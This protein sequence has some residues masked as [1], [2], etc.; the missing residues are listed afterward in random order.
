L[1]NA[2]YKVVL[3]PVTNFYF[4]MAHN[5]DV[6]EPGH[7]WANFTELR[8]VFAFNP[9]KMAGPNLTQLSP[10]GRANINGIEATMFSETMRD[11]SR[12]NYMLMPRLLGLAERAWAKPPLWESENSTVSDFAAGYTIFANQLS[13]QILPQLDKDMPNLAYRIAPPGAKVIEGQ[14][15]ANHQ[16]PGTTLRYSIGNT[17][18]NRNSP[19]YSRPIV[20]KGKI[21]IAAFSTSG[22]SSRTSTVNN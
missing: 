14:V 12:V 9:Y 7:D 16:L 22:R 1:A 17:S 18:P 13:K 10:Q 5:R 6:S 3:A 21:N 8:D 19:I 15:H 20:T 11:P 4:D 2:G